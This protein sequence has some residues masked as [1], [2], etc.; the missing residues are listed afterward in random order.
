[1]QGRSV[2]EC[3]SKEWFSQCASDWG[4]STQADNVLNILAEEGMFDLS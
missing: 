4:A 2:A 3:K 1:M